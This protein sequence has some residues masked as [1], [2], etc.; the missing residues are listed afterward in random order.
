MIEMTG[1]TMTGKNV[2]R[3]AGRFNVSIAKTAGV[4]A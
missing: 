1:L 3:P 4:F 2:V